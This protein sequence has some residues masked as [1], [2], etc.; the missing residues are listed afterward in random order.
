MANSQLYTLVYVTANNALLSEEA[1]VTMNR[2]SNS[3]AVHTVA[4]GYSGESPGAPTIELQIT[5][6]VPAAGFEFNA[7]QYIQQL[8]PAEMGLIGPGGQQLK[9]TGFIISDSLKHSVNAETQYDFTF[10]GSFQD[11]EGAIV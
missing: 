8:I 2:A 7:G 4:K 3:Q 10:R 9:A 5:N 1:S 6:A 11:F